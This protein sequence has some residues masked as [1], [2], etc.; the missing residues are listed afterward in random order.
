MSSLYFNAPIVT[1]TPQIGGAPAQSPRKQEGS[2]EASF[3][4]LLENQ[5]EAQR[6]LTFSKH[7][8]QRVTQRGIEI[9]QSSMERLHEGLRLAEE[10]G[11]AGDALILVDQ[12][13]FLVNV[14]NSKVITTLQSGEL[15]GN[16]FTNIDGTVII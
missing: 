3:Q 15:R 7:A 12:T 5:L 8:V 2:P 10:K 13:A 6:S 1:G 14:K 9:P 4:Q 11:L 16:V